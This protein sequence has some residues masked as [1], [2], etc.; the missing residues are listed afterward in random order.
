MARGRIHSVRTAA[1]LCKH[2]FLV[3]LGL[4]QITHDGLH[5]ANLSYQARIRTLSKKGDYCPTPQYAGTTQGLDSF[6]QDF[7][8][9]IISSCIKLGLICMLFWEVP[10]KVVGC[11]RIL[12]LK[13]YFIQPKNSLLVVM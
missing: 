11:H 3:L 5:Q 12:H 4:F 2:N 7:R 8:F 1:A 9:V 10:L 6:V 13:S